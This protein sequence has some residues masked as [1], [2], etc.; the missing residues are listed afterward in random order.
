MY[1]LKKKK[2]YLSPV[3]HALKPIATFKVLQKLKMTQTTKAKGNTE[4]S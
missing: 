2:N 4:M 1:Q 3:I